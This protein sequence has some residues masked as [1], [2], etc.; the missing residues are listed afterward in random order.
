MDFV[1][2]H[3]RIYE[4][5]TDLNLVISNFYSISSVYR[6]V[7][8]LLYKTHNLVQAF[9]IYL[10]KSRLWR[11]NRRPSF[12]F[13]SLKICGERLYHLD[14]G[15]TKRFSLNELTAYYYEL[16]RVKNIHFHLYLKKSSRELRA[17]IS[18]KPNDLDPEK[19][20]QPKIQ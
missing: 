2:L 17:R 3:E 10:E 9:K 19:K 20:I 6:Y 5:F 15:L 8:S 12:K 14:E 16:L 1:L 18:E 13:Q 7:Y 4:R 11:T